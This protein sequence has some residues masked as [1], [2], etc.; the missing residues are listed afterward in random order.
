MLGESQICDRDGTVLARLTLED[1]EGHVG[2]GRRPR[3]A[4]APLDAIQDRFWIPEMTLTTHARLARHER[5]R[6]AQLQAAPRA[7][8]ASTGRRWPAADLPDEVVSDA[9]AEMPAAR[10]SER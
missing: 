6:R 1:G 3:G 4:P 9:A 7:A 8:A 5:A 10:S 2:G